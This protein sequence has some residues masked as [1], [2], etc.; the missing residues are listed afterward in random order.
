MTAKLISQFI[1][2]PT[3]GL[4]LISDP[5][6]FEPNE[7]R[8]LDNYFIYDWG[9]RERGPFTAVTF[10]DSGRVFNMFSFCSISKRG[11]FVSTHTPNIYRYEASG[12]QTLMLAGSGFNEAF[13]QNRHLFF[14]LYG[15][16][17]CARYNLDTDTWANTSFTLPGGI[18]FYGGCAF[19][20]RAYFWTGLTG[21]I[22]YGGVDAITGLC[23]AFDFSPVFQRSTRVVCATAWSYNQGQT[24]DELFVVV[25]ETG[26]ILIYSGS[27]PA[28]P[29]WQL[30]TRVE[31]PV[32]LAS[33]IQGNQPSSHLVKTGQKILLNTARGVIDLGDV[34]SGKDASSSYFAVSRKL[35]TILCDSPGDKSNIA[36][37]AYFAGGTEGAYGRDVYILNYERGSWSK[38]P[39]IG[40]G[41]NTV[42]CISC[43]AQGVTF[44]GS[45]S[46]S[47]VLFGMDGGGL[48]RLNE[49]ATAADSTA[50]YKWAT[51][52]FNYQ[53]QSAVKK[54]IS[55]RLLGRDLAS[56]S[57]SHGLTMRADFDDANILGGDTKSKTVTTTDYTV[58]EF[59]PTANARWLS[60]VWS[61]TGSGSQLNEVGGMDTILEQGGSAY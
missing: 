47:Y 52:Y 20:N 22:Y 58:K 36:P 31:A 26:E 24:N 33:Y 48:L 41:T 17:A 1:S 50:T 6:N 2:P 42:R 54:A 51:P 9:I 13:A 10:A 25:G 55:A 34:V 15:S 60:Y 5:N 27:Y 40:T 29:N 38:F 59:T 32:P 45:N 28:D 46:D 18:L 30:V 14:P 23:T 43:S 53:N 61:K 11:T 57:F 39:T 37:F 3:G 56:T 35:G 19:K 49:S 4:N 8:I 44:G 12:T 21:T 7:A 16:T